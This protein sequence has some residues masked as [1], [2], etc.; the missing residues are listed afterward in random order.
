MQP[1]LLKSDVGFCHC[2]RLKLKFIRQ[3]F[4]SAI[5]IAFVML[6]HKYFRKLI[7]FYLT[8]FS[9]RDSF[10]LD[11][12]YLSKFSLG[13]N[14]NNS[15]YFKIK[16]KKIDSPHS[17]KSRFQK[18]TFY[19]KLLVKPVGVRELMARDCITTAQVYQYQ[20]TK[21]YKMKKY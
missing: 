2:I 20:Y 16:I 15:F 1:E 11:H 6:L 14:V 17:I 4:W 7:F 19:I 18:V 8:F 9:R 21:L 12:W 5:S 10:I 13:Q 3:I